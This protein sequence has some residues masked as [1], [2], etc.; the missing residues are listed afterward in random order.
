MKVKVENIE[1]TG[2]EQKQSK[3]EDG[4]DYLIVRFLD[5]TGKQHE[6]ID[7][8]LENKPFYKRHVE[9][10]LWLDLNMG[11]NWARLYVSSFKTR[12]AIEKAK[13]AVKADA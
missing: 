11:P 3:K 6:A 10:D 13:K 4:N 1:I 9:G 7:R 2:C 5:E 8:D 12:E